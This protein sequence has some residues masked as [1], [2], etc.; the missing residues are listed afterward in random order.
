MKKLIKPPKLN[1]GDKVAAI[2]LSSGSAG[3]DSKIWRYLQ[4]KERLERIFG[5]EVVEMPH[6]L[7]GTEY[8]Y[9]HP[10]ARAE[11]MMAAFSDP[12][13]KGIFSCI[14]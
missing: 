10:E 5:L 14:G 6:T 9:N 12:A 4:G 7:A 3:D 13:V 2:S 8:A 1:P 11:D